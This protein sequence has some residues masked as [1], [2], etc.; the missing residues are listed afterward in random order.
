MTEVHQQL[1]RIDRSFAPVAIEGEPRT[2]RYRIAGTYIRPSDGPPPVTGDTVT[3]T[4][5]FLTGTWSFTK[6]DEVETSQERFNLHVDNNRPYID[7]I[8]SPV[9][10][11]TGSP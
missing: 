4:F 6:D 9:N 3:V 5:T 7:V 10:G 1:V 11:E 2:F 8:L